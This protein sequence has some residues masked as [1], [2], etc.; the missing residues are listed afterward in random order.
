MCMTTISPFYYFW[1][2]IPVYCCL[3]V[4]MYLVEYIIFSKI[5]FIYSCRIIKKG[6]SLSENFSRGNI[7]G[8]KSSVMRSPTA[9]PPR[10]FLT[11]WFIGR[12]NITFCGHPVYDKIWSFL[13]SMDRSAYWFRSR[14]PTETGDCGAALSG[15]LCYRK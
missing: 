7:F 8:V 3:F 11:F 15:L 9:L 6:S 1:K 12:D 14:K 4:E 2:Y 5:C 10:K 13:V